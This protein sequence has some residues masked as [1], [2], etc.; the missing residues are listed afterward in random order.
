MKLTS[1]SAVHAPVVRIAALVFSPLALQ[2]PAVWIIRCGMLG[3]GLLFSSWK[4][5]LV[6]YGTD[7]RSFR[8]DSI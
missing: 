8:L 5:F 2:N 6:I 1:F 4:I 3:N 7:K